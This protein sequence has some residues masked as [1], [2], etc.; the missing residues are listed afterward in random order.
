[1]ASETV[2]LPLHEALHGLCELRIL[3]SHLKVVLEAGAPERGRA[4]PAW[5]SRYHC[6]GPVRKCVW[7][8]ASV[9]R[10][11]FADLLLAH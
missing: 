4:Q 10:A 2:Q 6:P 5:E 8:S 1:M 7:L 3:L 11:Q 9:A